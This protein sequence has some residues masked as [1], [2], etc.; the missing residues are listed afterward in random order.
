MIYCAGIYN[1]TYKEFV[2][3]RNAQAMECGVWSSG[4]RVI[5]KIRK[6]FMFGGDAIKKQLYEKKN[7]EAWVRQKKRY[8]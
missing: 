2:T 8:L 6:I 1:N 5:K 3:K 4:Y 7:N